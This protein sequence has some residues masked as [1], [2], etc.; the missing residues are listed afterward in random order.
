MR[1][2]LCGVQAVYFLPEGARA[3]AGSPGKLRIEQVKYV[4]RDCDLKL[5]FSVLNGGPQ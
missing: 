2:R 3:E 1:V 5:K 4:A